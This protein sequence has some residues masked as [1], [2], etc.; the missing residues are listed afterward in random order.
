MEETVKCS[1][2]LHFICVSNYSISMTSNQNNQSE[3][4]VLLDG[5]IGKKG[6][7]NL[8]RDAS[9]SQP[10]AYVLGPRAE[11]RGITVWA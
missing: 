2:D 8:P 6:A 1:V 11:T 3:F 10:A 7:Q 9:F 4:P 5:S